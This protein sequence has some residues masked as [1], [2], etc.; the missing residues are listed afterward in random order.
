[1][2]PDATVDSVLQT[3]YDYAEFVPGRRYTL[4]H[5]RGLKGPTPSG[6]AQTTKGDQFRRRLDRAL[7]DADESATVN[8]LIE[9]LY[10]WLLIS[11]PSPPHSSNFE[12]LVVALAMFHLA[13]GD[14]RMAII[15]AVNYGRD[16]DS[17]GSVAGEISGVFK[18]AS[19]IPEEWVTAFNKA[20]PE[21]D[22]A[23]TAR[24]MTEVV[25]GQ[26]RAMQERAEKILSLTRS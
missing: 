26:A 21:I 4:E 7:K 24:Q 12:W 19:A 10:K 8:E 5:I 6:Y 9:R 25:V 23:G 2:A 14:P 18:G 16:C 20:N 15:G 22:T 17:I 1:M 3:A 11:Y 13:K